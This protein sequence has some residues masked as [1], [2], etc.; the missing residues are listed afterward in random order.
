MKGISGG[1]TISARFLHQ[2]FFDFKP[3]A[4]LLFITNFYPFIDVEDKAFLRR[5]RI[6]KF[7]KNFSENSPD[8]HLQEKI[9]QE[10]SGI[11][12]WAIEGYRLY[13]KEG[14]CPSPNMLEALENYKKF[15]DPLDGF[16]E[17]IDLFVIPLKQRRDF[18]LSFPNKAMDAL[19][20]SKPILCSCSGSLV[21]F[22]EMNSC[23]FYFDPN[24]NDAL[25]NEPL[26]NENS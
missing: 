23:G 19:S 1:D 24:S 12:N 26:S 13:K 10:L 3:E 16:F 21:N 17:E 20:R 9:N 18:S 6:L 11:L 2:E 4:L 7:P 14:L 8:L 22:L 5:V 25:T 15:I